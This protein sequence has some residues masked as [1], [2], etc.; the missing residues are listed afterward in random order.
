MI[1]VT[2]A[3]ID[4]TSSIDWQSLT[5]Q[6]VATSEVDTAS[7][8]IKLYGTKTYQPAIGEEVLILDD[9]TAIFGGTIV[10]ISNTVEAGGLTSLN[11]ECASHERTLD[12]YLVAREIQNK[13]IFYCL[14]TLVAEFVNRTKKVIASMEDSETWTNEDGSTTQNTTAGQY[15]LET[16]SEKFT[17]TAGNTATARCERSLDL[18]VFDNGLASDDDDWITLWYYVDNPNN[19]A[20]LR[21]RLTIDAAGT[22]TNYYETT[23][24]STPR[25]G[26]NQAKIAKSAFTETGTPA[27]ASI[28]YLQIQA[29][30]GAGGTVNVSVDDIRLISADTGFTQQGVKDA[31]RTLGSVKFNYEQMSQAVKQI[32]EAVAY[33]W[34]IDAYRDINLY[35]PSGNPAPFSLTDTSQNFVWN[36]L[37][38]DDDLTNIRNQVYV[39]GGEYEGSSVTES[40]TADGQQLH[41]PTPYKMKDVSVTVAT[42][43]KTVGVDNLNDPADY[44]C[45]YNYMEKTLKF[46]SA[47]KPSSGQVVAITGTPMIPVIIKKYDATSVAQYGVFEHLIVDKSIITLQGGRD[48]AAAE[49]S[50]YRNEITE[51]SFETTTSG[52]IAGQ[53][54][55]INITARGISDTYRIKSI[56]FQAKSPSEFTYKIRL[57]TTRTFGI[58]EYL[59]DALKKDRKQIDLNDFEVTDLVQDIR[60]TITVTDVWTEMPRNTISEEATVEEVTQ[61]NLDFGYEWVLG[62]YVPTDIATDKKRVFITNGGRLI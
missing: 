19:F 50:A 11:I 25:T 31:S 17:A 2:I 23:I 1:T 26:W 35:E 34:Y 15:I 29:T 55:S 45:L 7:F 42:V 5:I 40:M 52:L 41:F 28:T 21:L 8:K 3:G 49:L 36:S 6:Q 56:N 57:V 61:D 44:D 33:E 48:R 10:R 32:A 43:A 16:Q 27:W 14:N 59:L 37:E 4:R 58:I 24:L 53:T 20:S 13:D 51:G 18:T 22:Y 47:T 9:A 39:R 12:R 62:P 38:L 30:A 46:K 60:E 54:I